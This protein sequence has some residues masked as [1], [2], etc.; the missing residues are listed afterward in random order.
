MRDIQRNQANQI[1]QTSAESSKSTVKSPPKNA[2]RRPL[3]APPIKLLTGDQA[4]LRR[5]SRQAVP[6][7]MPTPI[8][9]QSLPG[10]QWGYN[11]KVTESGVGGSTDEV[12]T[13]ESPDDMACMCGRPPADLGGCPCRARDEPP[14]DADAAVRSGVLV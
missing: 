12:Q 14:L 13:P 11:R 5:T 8:T 1:D 7:V 9:A 2:I 6:P 10:T 4:R 3:H